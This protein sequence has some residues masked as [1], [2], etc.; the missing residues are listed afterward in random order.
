MSKFSNLKIPG[1]DFETSIPH[2]DYPDVQILFLAVPEE[3]AD[4]EPESR[5]ME[6]LIISRV[7]QRNPAAWFRCYIRLEIPKLEKSTES[8]A[9]SHCTED[10]F[11]S[12]FRNEIFLEAVNELTYELF[13]NFGAEIRSLRLSSLH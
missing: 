8:L 9:I 11:E 5:E 7:E 3:V 10:S 4:I 12:F 13:E 1:F 2:P 6:D